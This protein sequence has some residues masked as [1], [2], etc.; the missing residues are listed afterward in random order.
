MFAIPEGYEFQAVT[1]ERPGNLEIDSAHF[2]LQKLDD[3]TCLFLRP[4]KGESRQRLDK[5]AKWFV[6]A[7][8]HF[9]ICQLTIKSK[10]G[11]PG[12]GKIDVAAEAK[13]TIDWVGTF[14][15]IA[16]QPDLGVKQPA[17][18]CLDF[19]NHI[20]KESIEVI[21]LLWDGDISSLAEKGEA[22]GIV[23]YAI[24]QENRVRQ[25]FL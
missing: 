8:P 10:D 17:I 14:T 9:A 13:K 22:I 2:F 1:G 4:M 6:P 7:I 18:R 19:H 23:A 21:G 11:I 24:K 3:F 5:I 20:F 12:S 25:G 16:K 15:G